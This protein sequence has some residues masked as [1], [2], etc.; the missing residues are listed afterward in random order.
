MWFKWLLTVRNNNIRQLQYFNIELF[1]KW[2]F[3]THLKWFPLINTSIQHLKL[4]GNKLL[5]LFYIFERSIQVQFKMLHCYS[6]QCITNS[7][8][9]TILLYV[10]Y[11][12]WLSANCLICFTNIESYCYVYRY[13]ACPKL[14]LFTGQFVLDS[15]VNADNY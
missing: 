13:V 2:S 6:I 5:L 10:G 14:A 1:L 9:F 8:C 3:T 4:L 12:Y 11:F 15:L 7:Y